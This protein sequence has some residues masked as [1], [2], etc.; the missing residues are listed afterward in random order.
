MVEK[1]QNKKTIWKFYKPKEP[2]LILNG[3]WHFNYL[4]KPMGISNKIKSFAHQEF[5]K[6]NFTDVNKIEKKIV[7]ISDIFGR[8]YIY[9]K[10]ELDSLFQNTYLII[11][12]NTESGFY[13]WCARKE[14]NPQPSDRSQ[15]LYPV[16]L[17]AL[18]LQSNAYVK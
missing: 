7:N 14:S 11:K 2:Q 17:Q 10:V 16:E 8:D 9:K 18:F 15:T 3:G 6:E 5:N 4:K 13:D 1:H 12:K